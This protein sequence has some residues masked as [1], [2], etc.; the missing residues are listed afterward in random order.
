MLESIFSIKITNNTGE[1]PF[2]ITGTIT[3]LRNDLKFQLIFEG[4]LGFLLKI[5][6]Y[7]C[8]SVDPVL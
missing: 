8:D 1:A 4:E 7:S 6:Q 3:E 2:G 5:D